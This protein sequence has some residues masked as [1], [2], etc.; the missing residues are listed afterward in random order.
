MI[1]SDYIKYES[2][3]RCMGYKLASVVLARVIR[4]GCFVGVF[5]WSLIELVWFNFYILHIKFWVIW[6][7]SLYN[8]KRSD[9]DPIRTA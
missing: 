4:V 5:N 6:M 8:D 3:G 1:I 7:L 9:S 2:S